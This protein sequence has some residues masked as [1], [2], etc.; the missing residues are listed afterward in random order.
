LWTSAAQNL[1]DLSAPMLMQRS[2]GSILDMTHLLN[3]RFSL[4]RQGILSIPANPI[5]STR[6]FLN[7]QN[8]E[9]VA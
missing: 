1:M 4:D 7:S 2:S 5:C 6:K 9:I 8:P 3:L